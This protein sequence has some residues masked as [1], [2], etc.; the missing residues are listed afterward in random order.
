MQMTFLNLS[1]LAQEVCLMN[2]LEEI[3]K[4]KRRKTNAECYTALEQ[5]INYLTYAKYSLHAKMFEMEATRLSPRL[6]KD[7]V[8]SLMLKQ[9][10]SK[11]MICQDF[12]V[13]LEKN[14]G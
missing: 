5:P 3:K 8:R 14:L 11:A 12:H 10:C 1:Q 7:F 2:H 13:S 4:I 6:W 9:K